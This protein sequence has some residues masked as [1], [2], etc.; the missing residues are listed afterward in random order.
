MLI[1]RPRRNT[2][3]SIFIF[4]IIL[5]AGIYFLLNLYNQ[6]G[7]WGWL[8]G[9]TFLGI[10][11][12]ALVL[13]I[14]FGYKVIKAEKNKFLVYYPFRF[15]RESYLLNDLIQWEIIIIETGKQ[16]FEEIKALFTN[17]KFSLNL[18]ENGNY[19]KFKQFFEKKA[20]K[21]RVKQ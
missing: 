7:H 1:S 13:K 19:K 15:R 4:I 14:M 20:P 10:I 16:P 5:I 2:L 3:F 21:K 17:G 18:P 8:I 12:V 9:I 11:A 6:N